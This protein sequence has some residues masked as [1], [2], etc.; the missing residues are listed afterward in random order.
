MFGDIANARP[1]KAVD[2]G[3]TAGGYL[4]GHLF[5]AGHGGKSAADGRW[6]R[7]VCD[8]VSRLSRIIPRGIIVATKRRS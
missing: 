1:R 5:P 4:A 6:F 3:D 7:G 8:Q 2:V